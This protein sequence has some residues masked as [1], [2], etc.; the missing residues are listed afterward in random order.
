MSIVKARQL[1]RDQTEAERAIWQK[2]RELKT[3]GFHFR[4]QAPMGKYIADFACQHARI[5]IE[6]DG[7][8][9]A[10]EDARVADAERT[11]WLR[12][13][14]YTVLRFWNNDVLSNLDGVMT[15]LRAALPPPQTPPRASGGGAFD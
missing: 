12:T 8:Q 2:L 7:G 13:R 14:G 1:R 3:E 6:I 4:H 15:I 9:H 10:L 5:V 11:A